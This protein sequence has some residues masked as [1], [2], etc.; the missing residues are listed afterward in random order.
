VGRD[1]KDCRVNTTVSGTEDRFVVWVWMWC[2]LF[3]KCMND[4]LPGWV[5]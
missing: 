5:Y 4:V 3:L 1:E 2:P